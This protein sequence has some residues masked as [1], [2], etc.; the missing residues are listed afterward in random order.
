MAG[1]TADTRLSW[2]GI[3]LRT[4]VLHT[5]G[6]QSRSTF[7]PDARD[8]GLMSYYKPTYRFSD[9]EAGIR[10]RLVSAYTSLFYNA[11]VKQWV[12]VVRLREGQCQPDAA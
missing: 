3:C 2:S 1:R 6:G 8:P 12:T 5:T 7:L 9:M 11:I 10:K 4:Q